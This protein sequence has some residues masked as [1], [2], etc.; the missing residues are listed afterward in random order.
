VQKTVTKQLLILFITLF[1]SD[2]LF[3]QSYNTQFYNESNGLFNSKVWSIIQDKSGRIWFGTRSG[4]SVYDGLSWSGFLNTDSIGG[5]ECFGLHEDEEGNIKALFR[6]P[7]FFVATHTK[8]GWKRL[9]VSGIITGNPICSFFVTGKSDNERVFVCTE[10]DGIFW[11]EGNSWKSFYPRTD[12]GLELIYS[13]CPLGDSVLLATEK[14][15]YFWNPSGETRGAGINFPTNPRG[16]YSKKEYGNKFYAAGEDWFGFWENGTVYT[17]SK[18]IVNA[19]DYNILS[20]RIEPDN[21]SGFY[22][23]NSFTLNY[24]SLLDTSVTRL[25]SK[26]GLITDGASCVFIDRENNTWIG[27]LRGANKISC[28]RFINYLDLFG[29]GEGEVSAI[30]EYEPGKIIFGGNNGYTMY[31]GTGFRHYPPSKPNINRSEKERILDFELDSKNNI[32][33]ASTTGG[34]QVIDKNGKRVNYPGITPLKERALSVIMDRDKNMWLVT[35]AGVYI[36]DGK[37]T[38]K[39]GEI[40]SNYIIR[41]AFALNENTLGFAT[42]QDGF[43]LKTKTGVTRYCTN[44]KESN[45]VYSLLKD[46]KGRLWIG[47]MA[48]LFELK[49]N[50]VQRALLNNGDTI[51][52]P[53]Y[54]L[55]EDKS[56]NLWIGTDF[57]VYKYN[58]K[59]IRAYSTKDG[60]AGNELN[61]P[62]EP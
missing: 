50:T 6:N 1:I 41:K 36:Y 62:E 52:R 45:S 3:P 35:N 38:R 24:F 21:N 29:E 54:L 12:Y 7:S 9:P 42:V 5:Y 31:D 40:P 37:E 43:Y 58:G 39:N 55:T 59:E 22:L 17:F 49:N 13:A 30:L 47:T 46:R 16:I 33:I 27:S 28:R 26:S 2:S 34:F 44:N 32:W 51:A 20:V 4:I 53:V 11:H 57:G 8:D 19:F 15:L 25:R 14:G 60:L 48:G 18:K 23:F 61:R 10:N 56:G